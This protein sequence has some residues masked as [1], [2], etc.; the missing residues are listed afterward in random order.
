ME[1]GVRRKDAEDQ[2]FVTAFTALIMAAHIQTYLERTISTAILL[3]GKC[4]M[5]HH[6]ADARVELMTGDFLFILTCKFHANF[7]MGVFATSL[8]AIVELDSHLVTK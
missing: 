8:K 4:A 7:I 5:C 6:P 3:K 1:D 2:F